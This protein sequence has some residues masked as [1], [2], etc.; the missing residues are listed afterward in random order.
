MNN[1]ERLHKIF[2]EIFGVSNVSDKTTRK[3][4]PEW[5]SMQT[6]NMVLA[7][8]EEFGVSLTPEEAAD[9][10]SVQIVKEILVEKGVSFEKG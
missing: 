3:D 1:T 9:M 5:N 2:R 10:L 7:I 8:E 6:I 4:I